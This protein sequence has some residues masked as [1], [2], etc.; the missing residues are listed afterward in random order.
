[1]ANELSNLSP[2]PGSRRPRLRVGRGEGSGKGK[3]CGRGT[4]GAGSRSGS[5]RRAYFEGGQMPLHRRLPKRGFKNLFA[6]EYEEV[7]LDKLADLPAGT[8]VTGAL[9]EERGLIARVGKDGVKLLARGELSVA[10]TV[11]LEK[12]SASA[13]AK[14]AAAGGTVESVGQA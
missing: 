12:V 3:T 7:N 5:K 8:V 13:A 1:M 4:K 6:K 9:L 10:L 14:I 11:R 2:N